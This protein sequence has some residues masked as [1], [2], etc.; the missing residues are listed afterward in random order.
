MSAPRTLEVPAS[1]GRIARRYSVGERAEGV[2]AAEDPGERGEVLVE[3]RQVTEPELLAVDLEPLVRLHAAS[4]SGRMFAFAPRTRDRRRGRSDAV[5]ARRRRSRIAC[6]SSQVA[7]AHCELRRLGAQRSTSSRTARAFAASSAST[8]HSG[9][10]SS[11]STSVETG[12]AAPDG[13]AIEVPDLALHVVAVRVEQVRAPCRRARRGA[14]A[15]PGRPGWRRCT[16]SASKP[17]LYALT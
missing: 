16:R 10:S 2:V 13:A 4:R 7:L 11:H 3:A 1:S 6:R 17:W 12:T 8:S 9:M 15:R 5:S 14:S